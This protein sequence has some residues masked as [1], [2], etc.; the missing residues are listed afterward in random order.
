M[1]FGITHKSNIV[2]RVLQG[3]FHDLPYI[4]VYVDDLTISTNGPLSHHTQCV[5]EVFCRLTK[6][7]LAISPEKM[8]LAQTSIHLLGWSIVDGASCPNP[9]EVST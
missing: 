7:N 4:Q 2:Q 9:R 5:A 3:L 8:V 6:A 1:C